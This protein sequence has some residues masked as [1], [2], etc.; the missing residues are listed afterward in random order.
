M[1]LP[2]PLHIFQK[3][4][5][6]LWP[7]TLVALVLFT[8]FAWTAPYGWHSSEY[9]PYLQ[10]LSWLLHVLMP[11]SWLVV[12]SRLIHDELLVG[13]RQFW[14]SRPY[15]WGMLLLAKV[16]YLLVFLYLPFFLMQVYLLKHAGLYPM[17]ALPALLHNL[18]LLTV[19]L[20]L[21]I[22]ALAAVTSTF[23]RLLLSFLGAILYCLLVA[24]IAGYVLF[25]TMPAPHLAAIILVLV[26]LLPAVAL[27]YQYATRRTAVARAILL[28]TP[29][30]VVLVVAL[31]PATAIIH[32]AYPIASGG[33]LPQFAAFPLPAGT[34]A[35]PGAPYVNHGDVTLRVPFN[36]TGEDK[37]SNYSVTGVASAVSGA[38]ADWSGGYVGGVNESINIGL[39]YVLL[40]ASIP[41]SVFDKVSTT[42]V[43]LH[44]SV[45]VDHMQ[46][47]ATTTWKS[48]AG[49]F[50][51]PDHGLCLFPTD[52]TG[53]PATPVCRFPL[54]APQYLV[55][56]APVTPGSCAEPS[57]Q[58]TQGTTVLANRISSFNFDPVVQLPLSLATGDRN[59]QHRYVLCA[60][61]PLSFI[62]AK[63]VGKMRFELDDKRVVLGPLA[64]RMVSPAAA[65]AQTEPA[66][67]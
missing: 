65:A 63:S 9:S 36:V 3:D 21:P 45:A 16:L 64:E 52:E 6:H 33:S 49:T 41:R 31:T 44:L 60:G 46:A 40:R 59:P 34:K 29:L 24:G 17:L 20:I 32:S 26:L 5:R 62:D 43:D 54:E 4:V 42:P 8:G 2:Q 58:Q 56:S 14:T 39:P 61:T 38:G 37:D 28:A 53:A 11:I 48:A 50:A 57:G 25:R 23:A 12:I 18:L 19:F 66:P 47:G 15:D 22:T 30:V 35:A 51:I 55:V 10:I 67:Q 7:E 1:A 27:V 13:D